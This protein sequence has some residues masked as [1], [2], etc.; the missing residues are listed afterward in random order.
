VRVFLIKIPYNFLQAG[1]IFVT[2]PENASDWKACFYNPAD[3]PVTGMRL[4]NIQ[5]GV[6]S[7]TRL[8]L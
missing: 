7:S 2:V 5:P 1:L 8:H 3:P 4:K 6:A